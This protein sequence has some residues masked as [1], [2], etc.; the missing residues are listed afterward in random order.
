MRS[1]FILGNNPVFS[2]GVKALLT[3]EAGFDLMGWESDMGTALECIKAHHPDVVIVDETD[4]VPGLI[5]SILALFQGRLGGKIVSLS[6]RDSYL[7]VYSLDHRVVR[8]VA[9]LIEA[10]A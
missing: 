9:D 1:V 10:I 2:Q 3:Q 4:L 7:R 8:D 5:P 6:L